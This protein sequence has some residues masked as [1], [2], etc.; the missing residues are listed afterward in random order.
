MPWLCSPEQYGASSAP[1][2]FSTTPSAKNFTVWAVSSG[3]STS[4]TRRRASAKSYYL[5]VEV[6]RVGVEG[7]VEPHAQRVAPGGLDVGVDIRR[8]D[9]GVLHPGDA[10]G[11]V[12]V[13]GRTEC[14][15]P[16]VLVARRH[17]GRDQVHCTPLTQRAEHRSVLAVRDLTEHRIR[18]VG[19]DA[20]ALQRNRVA[21]H[22]VVVPGPQHHRPIGHRGVEPAGVEQSVGREAAVVGGADD[23]FVVG[24]RR[25]RIRLR[26]RRFRRP[27]DMAAP[28]ARRTRARRSSG[29]A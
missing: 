6:A 14:R 16:D 26:R 22:G 17:H 29:W 9:P 28:A 27:S 4:S 1:V 8:L 3:D 12:V 13:G 19:G 21:P 23:P 24:V 11:Q 20:R 7:Q 15:H 10:A 25:R 18:G 5:G 2:S